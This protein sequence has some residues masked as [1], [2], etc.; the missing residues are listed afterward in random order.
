M[1]YEH[2]EETHNLKS[3]EVIVPIL[4]KLVQPKNVIDIGCGVGTFL[5]VFK[6]L[7]V[8]EVLGLDGEWANKNLLDKYLEPNEFRSANLSEVIDFNKKFDL[9][10]CLEVGE[11]I[12]E[13]YSENLVKTLVNA[14]SVII[15]SAAS[16][17]QHGQHHVN[18]QWP[19]YWINKF[20]KYDFHFHDLLRSTFWND[21]DVDFWYKQNMFLVMH[22]DKVLDGKIINELKQNTFNNIIHPDAFIKRSKLYLDIRDGKMST[23][24]YF[25]LLAKKFLNKIGVY[26][27]SKSYS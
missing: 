22:K 18:E 5:Y 7:G 13:D 2:K 12:P 17:Y 15:F 19:D 1:K 27:K 10:I 11:H 23:Y 26:K 3:P 9:A 8:K 21:P 25:S 14:S 20:L 4:Y 6:K 16:P 24:F